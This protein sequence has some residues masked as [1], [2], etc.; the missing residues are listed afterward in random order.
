[1]QELQQEYNHRILTCV[2]LVV[3]SHAHVLTKAVLYV[4]REF[5][6]LSPHDVKGNC[7]KAFDAGE[8]LGIP[9]VIEPADMDVLAVPDKLAVMT[10]LYQLRA[11]FTGEINT[12]KSYLGYKMLVCKI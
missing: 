9:R 8:A 1:M 2:F 6:S 11:H 7:K 3:I 12:N 5:D 4:C 10:Y